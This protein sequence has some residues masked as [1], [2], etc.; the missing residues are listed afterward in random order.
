MSNQRTN[1][2][3]CYADENPQGETKA[4]ESTE[5]GANTAQP[6]NP[7]APQTTQEGS[8]GKAGGF[9]STEPSVG[10]DPSSGQKPFQKQQ[11]GDRPNAAPEGAEEG[12]VKEQKDEGEE[13]LKKR[14]PD[15]HSGEPMKMH[16]QSESTGDTGEH[17]G[18]EGGGEQGKEKGTGEQ[19]VKS[20]GLAADGGDFDGEKKFRRPI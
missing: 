5:A 3:F 2:F 1:L 14:D 10:A 15:D 9:A 18:Q 13:L 8:S 4:M 20:S 11:G 19:Y 6:N 7:G 16:D 17:P 12:A